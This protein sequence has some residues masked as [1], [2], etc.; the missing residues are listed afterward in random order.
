MVDLVQERLSSWISKTRN[1]INEVTVPLVNT[2]HT[3]KV[4]DLGNS[5]VVEE[6]IEDMLMV[7]RTI[8]TDALGG[9]LSLAAI[10]SIEQFSR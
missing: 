5:L 9:N 10:V 1:L 7:E 2:G 6:D 3:N 8:D 4:D